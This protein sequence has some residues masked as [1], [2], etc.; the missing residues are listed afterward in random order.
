MSNSLKIEIGGGRSLLGWMSLDNR[1]TCDFNIITDELPVDDASVEY[2]YMSHVIEHIPISRAESVFRK[3]FR[4]LKTGGKLRVLC[5]DLE[6]MIR[7]YVTRDMT[8]FTSPDYQMGTVP[9]DY[10][11]L[12]PGGYL[13]GQ[14]MTSIVGDMNDSYLFSKKANG[15]LE[16]LCTCSHVSGWDFEMLKNILSVCEYR[17]IQRT[18]LEDIDPHKKMGQLCVNAYR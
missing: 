16:Y 7:A 12:G 2:V 18:G 1:T 15:K 3:I 14:I 4:K 6:E 8:V 5:P 9:S 13:V 11:R 17:D 10:T